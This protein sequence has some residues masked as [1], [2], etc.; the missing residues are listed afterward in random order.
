MTLP[1][2]F[3]PQSGQPGTVEG[4]DPVALLDLPDTFVLVRRSEPGD[5]IEAVVD[6][7]EVKLRQRLSE[8]APL[9]IGLATGRTMEPFYTALVARLLGW[10]AE[11]RG[12]L[13]RG[14]LSFN[15][16]EYVGLAA[17]HPASFA[18]FMH[19]RLGGPLGLTMQQMRVPDGVALNPDQEARA[20]QQDLLMAGGIGLQLLGLG[21]NGHVGFNEP[22]CNADAPCRCV[23]LCPVTR[24]QNAAAFEGDP[25]QV[26]AQAITLGLREILAAQEVHLIVTGAAKAEILQRVFAGGCDAAL[27]ASWLLRHPQ[28]RLWVDDAALGRVAA[29]P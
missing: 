4:G 8:P 2:P 15:L 10:T 14:W 1:W 29:L 18:A 24:A 17:S 26:P 7:W 16:D 27:P 28:V 19:Q 21:T 22:P 23:Q 9:P 11:D 25:A 20:Y 13:C 12:Q 6:H 5:L 3:F